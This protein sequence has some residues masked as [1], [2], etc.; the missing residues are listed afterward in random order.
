MNDIDDYRQQLSEY[1]HRAFQRHLV[2]GTGGNLSLR[3]PGTDT[4]LVTPTGISLAEV[5]PDENILVNLAGDIIDSPKGLKSSKETGF[6][7]AAYNLKPE[8][9][10]IAH[11]HPP[12]ATAYANKAAPLPL[13]TISAQVILK[14]VPWI[15]CFPP[16]SL[17]LRDCVIDGINQNSEAC[18]IL[19]KAHGILAMGRDLRHAFYIADLTEDTAKIAYISATIAG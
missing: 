5:Q 14:H 12:Y 1:S 4:V 17:A 18:C 7:L 8:I 11:V 19:M 3:I 13:A 10:G 9:G 16:G 2:S 6:H 15:E